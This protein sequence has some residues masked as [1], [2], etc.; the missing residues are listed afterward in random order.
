MKAF[1]GSPVGEFVK[2]GAHLANEVIMKQGDKLLLLRRPKGLFNA[3]RNDWFF[4]HGEFL[5]G[6]TLEE[7]ARRLVREQ[8]GLDIRE[9]RIVHSWIFI[10]SEHWFIVLVSMAEVYGEPRPDTEVAEWKFFT[11]PELPSSTAYWKPGELTSV[12]GPFLA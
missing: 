4:A 5:Y 10:D 6:E 9:V 12:L 7:C 11:I 8:A 1:F 2:G 3:N